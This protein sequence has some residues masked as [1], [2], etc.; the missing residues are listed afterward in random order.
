MTL[1][2]YKNKQCW[3]YLCSFIVVMLLVSEL[4]AG[5]PGKEVTVNGKVTSA[6]D[7]SGIPGVNVVVKG[8]QTGT[9]T[10][11]DGKYSVTS[12][13]NNGT[14]VFSYIGFVTQEV[15]IGGRSNID[16]SLVVSTEALNEVVVTAIG[17][18]RSEQSLGYSVGK[19][20]GDDITHVAQENVLN[21][22]A[23]RVAGVT[24]NSTG[25]AGSS[26]QM[27]IRGTKSLVN[28]NQ[29][30]FVID[31]VPVVNSLNNIGGVGSDNRVDY[32]NP[33]SDLNPEIIESI[34]VLKG[35]SAAAL[36]GSR[37][38]NGVVI[39]TTKNGSKSKRVTVN[40]T[41]NT[42]FDIPFKYLDLHTKFASGYLPFTPTNNLES[43]GILRV[44]ETSVGGVGPELDK[45]YN[46]IQW[47]S[48]LDADGNPIPTPLVSHKDNI[49]NFVRT[50]ITTTNGV[51]VS[52]SNDML[53]YGCHIEYDKPGNNSKFRL[54]QECVQFKYCS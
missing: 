46:A 10:D 54:V 23:G 15:S 21:S 38:G 13:D 17:I 29:P 6:D 50:G 19:V 53:T 27:T 2:F 45:G 14:L 37:A 1:N 34:S 43:D 7:G 39:I 3:S 20:K 35:P 51:S 36:Y 5:V 12:A 44:D 9:I 47:N 24:I 41:S 48:P 52:N 30:L 42:V 18:E 31:G 32:G 28:D 26:V 4:D 16:V 25:G 40:V 49:K 22:L 8:T 33:I 11:A